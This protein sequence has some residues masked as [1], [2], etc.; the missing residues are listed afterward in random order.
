[1]T[2][3]KKTIVVT[4]G[5]TGG[6]DDDDDT[7][8]GVPPT[9][10]TFPIEV[11]EG[12]DYVYSMEDLWPHMGDYDMN[13]FV[14]K[15]HAITKYVNSSNKVEKM[16]FQLTPLASGST[17]MVSAALQLDGVA[18]GAISVVSTQDIARIDQGHTQANVIL[19]ENVHALFGLSATSA[20]SSIFS[21]VSIDEISSLV[22]KF[23]RSLM[24]KRIRKTFSSR[25]VSVVRIFRVCSAR[26]ILIVASEGDMTLL[27]SIKSPR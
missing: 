18:E 1:M 22:R 12:T 25:E 4:G 17:K 8:G 3:T 23:E 21:T 24:P 26:S 13:D 10:P 2:Q 16:T 20:T 27:S 7:G 6:D 11:V 19:F 15:I 5:G 14:F 9:D